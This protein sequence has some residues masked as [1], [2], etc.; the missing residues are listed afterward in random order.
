MSIEQKVFLSLLRDYVQG[1]V[2]T[3]IPDT[4]N[5][6]QL[7]SYAGEQSLLGIC[8]AQL[9]II[10]R[11]R[12]AIPE[13]VL[14]Q[15]HQGFF[16]DIY[17]SMNQQALY[18]E[19][20]GHF[21]SAEIE[22]CPF[23][24]YIVRTY[25]PVPE[26]RTMGDIDILIHDS[27][28]Q[29]SDTV[30]KNLGYKRLIDNHAVWTYYAEDIVFELHDHM[31]YETLTQNIDYRC[32]FDNAWSFLHSNL[33]ESFHFLYIIAHLAKHTINKGMGFRAYLDLVFFCRSV[34]ERLDWDWISKELES[35]KLLSFTETCFAFCRKWFGFVPPIATGELEEDFFFAVT[36]K[37][38][39]DG[40]YGLENR[41]NTGSHAAKEIMYSGKSYWTGAIL[42][43][44]HRLFPSYKDMQLISWYA[45][46]DGRP[47]L[48]PVAW[49]YR[50]WYCLVHKS[51]HGRELLLEPFSKRKMIE[52]RKNLIRDWGL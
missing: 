11:K 33:R 9:K 38:F 46:L 25:W 42:V 3:C 5:W 17:K 6:T 10:H 43:A 36:Q 15:F 7:F 24:G 48:M 30:M 2:D 49:A 13:H 26:L 50:W 22:F 20:C 45:F 16:Q 19:L 28:R 14:E 37:L 40:T 31:F 34:G 1:T 27:D 29:A 8:Y 32:Y 52:R 39:N 47:W 23:K 18:Q 51:R 44:L 21:D 12:K 35:L 4:L 41:Q